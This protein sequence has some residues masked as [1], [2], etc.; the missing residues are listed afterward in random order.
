[1]NVSRKIACALGLILI[2]A[3]VFVLGCGDGSNS[4]P[5]KGRA[6]DIQ[7]KVTRVDVEK[8]KVKIDHQDIPGLMKGMDMEFDVGDAKVLEGIQPGDTVHGRLKVTSGEYT[9]TELHKQ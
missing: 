7:G 4:S 5:E 1:M 2:V 6:Y 3:T 8:K 9:I